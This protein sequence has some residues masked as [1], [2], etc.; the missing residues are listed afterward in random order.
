MWWNASE[1]NNSVRPHYLCLAFAWVEQPSVFCN[2]NDIF[3][4]RAFLYVLV[5]AQLQEHKLS[6]S[7]IPEVFAINCSYSYHSFSLYYL[8]EELFILSKIS[9]RAATKNT[10]DCNKFHISSLSHARFCS[11]SSLC[12]PCSS[13]HSVELEHIFWSGNVRSR[14]DFPVTL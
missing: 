12:H 2:M 7:I 1:L 8:V 5:V 14:S 13:F 4:F 9:V 10:K 6:S 3:H 11:N